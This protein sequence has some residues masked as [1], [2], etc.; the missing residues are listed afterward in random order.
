MVAAKKSPDCMI[1][2]M[3]LVMDKVKELGPDVQGLKTNVSKLLKD[4]ANHEKLFRTG[5]KKSRAA[6]AA[7]D[8]VDDLRRMFDESY[9]S[10]E[11]FSW[12]NSRKVE[13]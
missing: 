6:V 5:S 2:V 8:A 4:S 1:E 13:F 7:A 11:D 3:K 9:M 12:G 10:N